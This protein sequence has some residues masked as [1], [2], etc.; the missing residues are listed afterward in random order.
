M[1]RKNLL[2]NSTHS[3]EAVTMDLIWSVCGIRLNTTANG[4]QA[5]AI[6]VHAEMI[7]MR[8]F[9]LRQSSSKG[10]G[11]RIRRSVLHFAFSAD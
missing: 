11:V 4:A 7:C 5:L 6:N 10:L 8:E 2:A 1:A 3:A 9:K